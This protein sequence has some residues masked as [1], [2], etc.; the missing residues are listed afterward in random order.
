MLCKEFVY[1]PEQVE[2]ACRAGAD[3]V[4]LIARALTDSELG[5]LYGRIEFLGMLPLVEVHRAEELART[6]SLG[7]SVIMVNSRDLESLK[8]DRDE[9]ARTLEATPT[10]I[11]K[12]LAS[13][14]ESRTDIEFFRGA[15]A[16]TFLVGSALMRSTAPG[17]KIRELCDVR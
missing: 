15:G 12:I 1:F 8:I 5:A 17:E 6:R 10:W 9:A 16:E 14:I 4:L 3:M 13:G 7:C 2:C 11:T